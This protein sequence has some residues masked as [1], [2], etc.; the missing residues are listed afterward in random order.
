[1]LLHLQG[2]NLLLLSVSQVIGGGPLGAAAPVD[3]M[4]PFVLLV[5]ERGK[6]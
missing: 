5:V 6:S 3:I 2:H 4:P 1:M